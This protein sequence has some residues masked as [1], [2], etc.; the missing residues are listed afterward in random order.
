MPILFPGCSNPSR[1]APTK[2]VRCRCGGH[3]KGQPPGATICSPTPGATTTPQE[4]GDL[5]ALPRDPEC[6]GQASGLVPTP[7]AKQQRTAD[8]RAATPEGPP[9][10]LIVT[11]DNFQWPPQAGV[12]TEAASS[13]TSVPVAPQPQRT[14]TPPQH[15]PPVAPTS[16]PRARSQG[17]YH[18]TPATAL[19]TPA[20]SQERQEAREEVVRPPPYSQE[21]IAAPAQ[22]RY[23]LGPHGRGR[24][25]Q[26]LREEQ[27]SLPYARGFD[28]GV[29]AR[30]FPRNIPDD[31]EAQR[32]HDVGRGY[33]SQT[34]SSPRR[35]MPMKIPPREYDPGFRASRSAVSPNPGAAFG[36]GAR[37]II[38]GNVAFDGSHHHPSGRTDHSKW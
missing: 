7:P 11:S 35:R 1:M 26:E 27:Q 8:G 3:A 9:A 12:P 21:D 6:P 14:A 34:G 31:Y 23:S 32:D 36:T 18:G 37:A 30:H 24:A 17:A 38:S 10:P 25:R 2:R 5:R 19:P 4:P 22:D 16:A 13:S 28:R 29:G 20:R 33:Y 15:R